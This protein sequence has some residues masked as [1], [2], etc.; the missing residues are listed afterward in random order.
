M[1]RGRDPN[2][3]AIGHL[4]ILLARP[5]GVLPKAERPKGGLFR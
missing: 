3:I 5:K 2:G 4:M 1:D